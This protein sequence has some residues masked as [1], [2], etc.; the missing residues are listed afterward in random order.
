MNLT[1]TGKA[2]PHVPGY[3]LQNEIPWRG[4]DAYRLV[5][6]LENL[7]AQISNSGGSQ[8]PWLSDIDGDGY[9]LNNANLGLATGAITFV[10]SSPGDGITFNLNTGTFSVL[11]GTCSFA[12]VD[13]LGTI[14]AYSDNGFS[15]EN[16]LLVDSIKGLFGELLIATT[17]NKDLTINIDGAG[18]LIINGSIGAT[19]QV[20]AAQLATQNLNFLYGVFIGLV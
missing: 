10:E 16:G 18:D 5:T 15:I 11:S 3:F 8:T 2:L 4:S 9:T 17:D 7:Q 19:Q 13:S 14:A 12:V 20:S 1:L 6:D